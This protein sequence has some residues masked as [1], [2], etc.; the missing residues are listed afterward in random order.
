MEKLFGYLEG[1]LTRFW[2]EMD[3]LMWDSGAVEVS[4]WFSK[5]WYKILWVL[6]G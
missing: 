3:N 2:G 6:K 1:F 4:G 5:V